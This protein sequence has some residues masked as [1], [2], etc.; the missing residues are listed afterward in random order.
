MNT[1]APDGRTISISPHARG[2]LWSIS[3]DAGQAEILGCS[4][5]QERAILRSAMA[6]GDSTGMKLAKVLEAFRGAA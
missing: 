5:T 1:R 6:W 3:G 4:P 2:W